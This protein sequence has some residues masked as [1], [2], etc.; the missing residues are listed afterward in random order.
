[1]AET[2]DS[3]PYAAPLPEDHSLEAAKQR[4][5]VVDFVPIMVRWERLRWFYNGSLVFFVLF[6]SF[7]LFPGNTTE[8][9]FWAVVCLGGFVANLCFMTGPAIEAY[10][11]RFGIWHPLLTWMLFLAGLAFTALLAAYTI[12]IYPSLLG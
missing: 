2:S 5:Q 4:A 11:T 1:M 12:A 3:N 10:G 7:V 6:I 9:D 8:L